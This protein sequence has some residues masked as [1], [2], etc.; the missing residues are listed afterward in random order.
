MHNNS[1]IILEIYSAIITTFNVNNIYS[2]NRWWINQE[3]KYML[4]KRLFRLWFIY[5]KNFH[6]HDWKKI[7]EFN[8]KTFQ[9]KFVTKEKLDEME[10]LQIINNLYNC[11][12]FRMVRFFFKKN[13]FCIFNLRYDNNIYIDMIS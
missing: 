8:Q 10:E 5:K 4:L 2:K 7:R 6:R 9:K 13:K 3:T 1:H 12:F 11:N